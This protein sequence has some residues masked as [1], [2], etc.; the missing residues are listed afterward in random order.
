MNEHL[1]LS[2]VEVLVLTRLLPVGEKGETKAKIQKDLEPLLGH[3]WSG[4]VLTDVLDRTLIK[5]VSKGLVA[6]RP[7]KSKKAM[8]A[9]EL[10][11][12]GRQSIL[13]FL[14]V[15]QL[16]TKPKPSWT[17]LK[18]SLLMA[19][20]L[21]LPGPGES[22]SKDDRFRAV[23]LKRQYDL[24]LGDYPVL[25]QAKAEWMRKTLGM[26]AKEKVTLETVQVSLLKKELGDAAPTDSK[27]VLNRLLARQLR[28]RRD[29]T[30]ELRDEVLRRWV[31]RSLGIPESR[32]EPPPCSAVRS[33]SLCFPRCG[34]SPRLSDG[35][36]WP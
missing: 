34:C 27:K 28:A 2:A 5:L 6:H 9:V 3:R 10:T 25:K 31:N 15:K 23:L 30:K 12:F 14:K 1:P 33:A 32:V 18:H 21:E 19:P 11:P 8:P 13:E 35:S 36:L 17:K 7:V 22:L 29:D 26:G 4:S 20:A 16:P 24:P